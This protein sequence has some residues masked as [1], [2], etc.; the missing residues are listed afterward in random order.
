MY[1]SVGMVQ[2]RELQHALWARRYEARDGVGGGALVESDWPQK[3]GENACI[4]SFDPAVP[5]SHV[6]VE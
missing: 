3:E 1:H 5:R 2:G 6:S 4:L